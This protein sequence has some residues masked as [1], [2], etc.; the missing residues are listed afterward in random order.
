M[1]AAAVPFIFDNREWVARISA[2]LCGAAFAAITSNLA[3]THE[4]PTTKPPIQITLAEIPV[5][6]KPPPLAEP[7]PPPP[8]PLPRVSQQ[9]IMPAAEPPATPVAAPTP[10]PTA[11]PSAMSLPDLPVAP[12]AKSI[13]ESVE[14][15]RSNGAAEGRFA[16][17]VRAKIE[18]KK[19]FP[20]T[21]RELGM[22]GTVEVAYVLDRS[23]KLLKTEVAVSSG[24]PLLDQAAVRAVRSAVYAAFPQ[25]AWIGEAQK[26]FHTKLVFSIIN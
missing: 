23:G 18:Q 26:E 1:T 22:S 16:Q 10:A 24:Y 17:D 9:K 13:P 6:V 3:I 20:E 14:T 11:A 21:A 4:S 25:D 5:P 12:A 8:T 2:L 15:P 19:I 7:P